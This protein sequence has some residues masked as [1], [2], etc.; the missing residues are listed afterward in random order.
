MTNYGPRSDGPK[1]R[2]ASRY[3]HVQCDTDE[4]LSETGRLRAREDIEAPLMMGRQ[5]SLRISRNLWPLIG[6]SA[7]YFADVCIRAS[8]KYFWYDELFTVYLSRLPN[9]RSLWDALRHGADFNP[10]LV[11]LLTKISQAIF[12]TGLIST[13]LPEIVGFWVMCICLYEFVKRRAGRL[14]GSVAMM[15]P[16]LTGAFYYAYEARPY[17]IILG[18]CGLA[19]V[20]WQKV[21]DASARGWWLTGLSVFLFAAFMLQCYAVVIVVPFA[22]VEAFRSLRSKRVEWAMW[23]ALL[24]PVIVAVPSYIPLLRVYSSQAAGSNYARAF[25]ADWAQITKF[26]L[27]LL[28][29]WLLIGL[30]TVVLIA[31]DRIRNSQSET[32]LRRWDSNVASEIGLVVCLIAVPAFGVVL[33][34]L[35]H[36]P[37]FARYFLS[38]T[39]GV[40]ALAGLALGAR[41]RAN[42]IALIVATIV[43]VTLAFQFTRLLWH[44]YKGWGEPLTEPST[45]ITLDTTPGQPLDNHPLLVSQ[46]HGSLPIG[47]PLSLDFLYL[48]YYSPELAP[49]LYLLGGSDRDFSLVGFRRVHEWIPVKYDH[50]LTYDEFLRSFPNSL[51]YGDTVASLAGLA[52]RGATIESLRSAGTHFLAA[53]KTSGS[54]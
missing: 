45:H 48:K 49:R 42:T 52:Q 37:F 19:L 46:L 9:F 2:R 3:R 28:T 47:V 38:A 39:I 34:K 40:C 10:P 27:F 31:I 30:V 17:G 25:T 5:K 53:I 51:L 23:V 7:F 20:S 33:G 24:A 21:L 41:N 4:V 15:L 1:R 8:Q 54:R 22:L 26:Y 16:M 44:S 50:L 13:R 11:Y 36:G 32:E 18:L 43:A 29:P 12:G 35:V 14:P 6:F